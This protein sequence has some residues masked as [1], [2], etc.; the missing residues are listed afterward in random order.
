MGGRDG[1]GVIGGE[2]VLQ[3]TRAAPQ[4]GRAVGTAAT[5]ERVHIPALP[6]LRNLQPPGPG[7]VPPSIRSVTQRLGLP[8]DDATRFMSDPA[9]P[10]SQ[11][12]VKH[13]F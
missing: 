2:M 5:A 3:S 8:A 1:S 7:P 10:I 12:L 6:S 13:G 4:Q 9:K 11:L